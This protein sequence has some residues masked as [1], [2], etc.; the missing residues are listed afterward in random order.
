MSGAASRHPLIS[1]YCASLHCF[2]LITCDLYIH[3]GHHDNK[4][5]SGF[6]SS[7]F[8]ENVDLVLTKFF[9]V[10]YL[11]LELFASESEVIMANK[12]KHY[13]SRKCFKNG[14]GKADKID[15]QIRTLREG[16]QCH[17]PRL[18]LCIL[19]LLTWRMRFPVCPFLDIWGLDGVRIPRLSLADRRFRICSQL[20]PIINNT[21]TPGF[22]NS[23]LD[24]NTQIFC[25]SPLDSFYII[26]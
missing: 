14:W 1:S 9:F 7:V 22:L 13:P 25:Q 5:C 15:Q 8:T 23:G 19:Q 10:V 11:E 4:I 12:K 16:G 18:C 17:I 3:N 6:G 26:I 24:P 20:H 21:V 2:R